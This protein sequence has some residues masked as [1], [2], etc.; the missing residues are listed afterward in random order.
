MK[1]HSK[2]ETF[3]EFDPNEEFPEEQEETFNEN[4]YDK[5]IKD[6]PYEEEE[7]EEVQEPVKE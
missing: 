7:I 2:E 6:E 3:K 1:I 4:D 5:Y